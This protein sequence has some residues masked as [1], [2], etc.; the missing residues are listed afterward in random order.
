MKLMDLLLMHK[1][2]ALVVIS[3]KH[4]KVELLE[5][6]EQ[7]HAVD[8]RTPENSGVEVPAQALFWG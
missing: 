4:V 5:C 2:I 8:P 6:D 1:V 7:G 3:Y